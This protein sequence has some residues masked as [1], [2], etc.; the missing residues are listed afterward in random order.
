M[1]TGATRHSPRFALISAGRDGTTSG[2][3]HNVMA[4]IIRLYKDSR[5]YLQGGVV[6][7]TQ[8]SNWEGPKNSFQARKLQ[9]AGLEYVGV[10][11]FARTVPWRL[12]LRF[13]TFDGSF[14]RVVGIVATMFV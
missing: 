3:R 2:A 4:E 1:T 10:E 13:S 7:Y 9:G 5:V 8:R 11:T 12:K 14:L 6:L